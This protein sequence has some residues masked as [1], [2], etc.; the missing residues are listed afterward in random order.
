MS[1]CRMSRCQGFCSSFERMR[2]LT[3]PTRTLTTPGKAAKAPH[4]DGKRQCPPTE[5]TIE[6]DVSSQWNV[7]R[8]HVRLAKAVGPDTAKSGR[9]MAIRH[10]EARCA[11]RRERVVRPPEHT[12]SRIRAGKRHGVI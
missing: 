2:V 10:G 6:G 4:H 5:L 7:H 3:R 8:L 12:P 9:G 11:V 1:W